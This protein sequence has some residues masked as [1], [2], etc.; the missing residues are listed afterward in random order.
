MGDE[1]LPD[2]S[3]GNASSSI[4]QR[5]PAH[6]NL[7]NGFTC[8][9]CD[10]VL[11][12]NLDC[13]Q[14]YEARMGGLP[15][16]RPKMD[17]HVYHSKDWDA[18]ATLTLDRRS[19]T[20][21]KPWSDWTGPISKYHAEDRRGRLML[22]YVIPVHY[23]PKRCEQCVKDKYRW[24]TVKKL[25]KQLIDRTSNLRD[26]TLL[27][28]TLGEAVE[29]VVDEDMVDQVVAHYRAEMKTAFMKF[30][31]SKW[32]RNRVK[33]W[34]YTIEVKVSYNEET[35]KHKFHPH[36]HCLA[37]H[38]DEEDFKAAAAE[39]GLGTYTFAKRVRSTGK[40]RTQTKALE[41][42]I[43]YV[44]KYALKGYGDPSVKRYYETG[45]D[46]RKPSKG[47]EGSAKA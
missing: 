4:R 25:K 6:P 33:G 37:E 26:V 7:K 1:H 14:C 15:C 30:T 43:G 16:N 47:P 8:H 18:D 19:A 24:T 20:S 3:D 29:D 34:F 11:P 28:F 44:M 21:F 45:G 40:H 13:I 42:A 23:Y 5:R 35:G 9:L 27:T 36:V 31:R 46:Y 39:R 17:V 2:L 12:S 41:A 22:S 32:W 10:I 38:P